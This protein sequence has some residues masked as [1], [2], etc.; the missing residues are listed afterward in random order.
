MQF[1][2]GLQDI[3]TETAQILTGLGAHGNHIYLYGSTLDRNRKITVATHL[4]FQSEFIFLPL[5][6]FYLA[7]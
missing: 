1:L 2:Y 4:R 6:A 3:G 5:L 7:K